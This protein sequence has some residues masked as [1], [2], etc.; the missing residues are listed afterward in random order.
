[1]WTTSTVKSDLTSRHQPGG[2]SGTMWSGVNLGLR[3]GGCIYFFY[4][5]YPLVF[6][7]L[8]M[9]CHCAVHCK[10][11]PCPRDWIRHK[12]HCLYFSNDR[13]TWDLS[14]KFCVS[15]NSKLTQLDSQEKKVTPL[16]DMLLY[17]AYHLHQ[18]TEQEF[19]HNTERL[20]EV[21]LER[22][23]SGLMIQT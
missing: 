12:G 5:S 7:I 11:D 10:V 14:R 22:S 17:T 18:H 15:N 9:L 21:S 8:C 20:S 23:E 1:Y 2:I 3:G 16:Y 4:S 6:Y 13:L 19:L